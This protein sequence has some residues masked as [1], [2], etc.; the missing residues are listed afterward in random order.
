MTD[1]FEK[2]NAQIRCFSDDEGHDVMMI[3]VK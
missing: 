1:T 2:P 3:G